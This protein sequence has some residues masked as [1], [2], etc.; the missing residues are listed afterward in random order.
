MRYSDPRRYEVLSR[1]SIYR[2]IISDETYLETFN[3]N[4][5]E[6]SDSDKFHIVTKREENRLDIISN[7]FYG[8]PNYW[9]ILAIANELIDPFIVN[10]GDSI[11]IPPIESLFKLNGVLYKP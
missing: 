3:Q 4:T 1:Y 8:T 7:D 9:W 10:V 11:R 2:Q 6:K 5:I